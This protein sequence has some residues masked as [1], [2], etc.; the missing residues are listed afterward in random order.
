LSDEKNG[1]FDT[2]GYL[3][4]TTPDGFKVELNKYRGEVNG[5]MQEITK[6]EYEERLKKRIDTV[7]KKAA[8]M[9]LWELLENTRHSF[10]AA[11]AFNKLSE[12]EQKDIENHLLNLCRCY[13][14][15]DFWK[16]NTWEI[17]HE[18]CE[19]KISDDY[20][21]E[22]KEIGNYLQIILEKIKE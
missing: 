2:V 18:L 15:P 16:Y 13:E 4:V 10:D 8:E 22:I 14:N 9:L 7:S 11:G 19:N 3:Y 5:K 20:P 17:Y 21:Q 12:E 6:E 1:D